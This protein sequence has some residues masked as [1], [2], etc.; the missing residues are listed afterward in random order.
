MKGLGSEDGEG[1]DGNV[2]QDPEGGYTEDHGPYELGVNEDGCGGR[3]SEG[4]QSSRNEGIRKEGQREYREQI[5]PEC[6]Q[7][8]AVEK[9]V[10]GPQCA[11]ARAV[12]AGQ[13]EKGTDRIVAR[14]PG[15]EDIKHSGSAKG[16]EAR[17]YIDGPLGESVSAN[18]L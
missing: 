4:S 12:V 6:V 13:A 18:R 15:V 8:A 9:L 10:Q 5:V 3:G 1:L 14:F 17:D 16:H 7:G 2:P 11:A